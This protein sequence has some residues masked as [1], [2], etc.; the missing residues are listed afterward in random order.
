MEK[1]RK[2][3]QALDASIEKVTKQPLKTLV[4]TTSLSLY[5]HMQAKAALSVKI[6]KVYNNIHLYTVPL[7]FVVL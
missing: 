1:S 3:V 4:V 7:K 5:V 2:Q 6:K